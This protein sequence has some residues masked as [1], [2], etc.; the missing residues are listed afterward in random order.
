LRYLSQVFQVAPNNRESLE[1]AATIHFEL[2]EYSEAEEYLS[3]LL[4]I[5]PAN[6]QYRR[7]L[8]AVQ[9]AAGRLSTS[10]GDMARVDI[11]GLVDPQLLA[12]LGTAYMKHGNFVDGTRSFE[13]AY[14]LAPDSTPIRTQLAFS[15]LRSGN[16]Q[17]AL[18]DLAT[19]RAEAPE[20][21]LAGVLQALGY[22]AQELSQSRMI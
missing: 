8:G 18:A 11:E 19:I 12:L 5:D 2:N 4:T 17:E 15:K 13:R 6:E 3:R 10:I 14:E 16:I 21:A 1:Q 7:T 22:A 20:Y 9:L